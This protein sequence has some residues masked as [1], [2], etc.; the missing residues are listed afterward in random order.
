MK[1]SIVTTLYMSEHHLQEFCERIRR[2]AHR[3]AEEDYEMIM[4]NDGSPDKSL[5][6]AVAL[7]AVY[8]NLRVVDLSRNFGHHQAMR[9]GL[10]HTVGERVFLIDSDLEE[11]PEWLE[12]FDRE[13]TE[14]ECDI[15]IGAQAKRKGRW[16]ERLTGAVFWHLFSMIGSSVT[17]KDQTTAR[18][19]TR[20]FIN[21]LLRFTEKELFLHGVMELVGFEVSTVVVKKGMTS[22]STYSLRRRVALLLNAIT[23]FS[24]APLMWALWVGALIAFISTAYALTLVYRKVMWDYVVEGW[25]SVMVSIWIFS[26]VIISLIG[27]VGL[28]IAK[29]FSETKRRPSTIIKDVYK[30]GAILKGKSSGSRFPHYLT[31]DD[32]LP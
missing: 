6:V 13:L 28:Y 29:I 11:Q 26:G 8:P 22:P 10:S 3:I 15:V 12:V 31:A 14:R 23:S 16:G 19:M 32:R 1:L 9:A 7:S 17:I 30:D 21:S 4:V 25:T 24:T 2:V 20:R 5:E 18:L 27:I